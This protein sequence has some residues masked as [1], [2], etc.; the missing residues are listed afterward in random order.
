MEENDG[1]SADIRKSIKEAYLSQN[2]WKRKKA[3]LLLVSD[4]DISVEEEIP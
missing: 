3:F 2:F 1:E 4:D